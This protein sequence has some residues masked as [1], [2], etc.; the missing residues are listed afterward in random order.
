MS[1]FFATISVSE[2]GWSVIVVGVVVAIIRGDLVP[3]STHESVKEDRDFWRE[4]ARRAI[5]VND[6]AVAVAEKVAD[7]DSGTKSPRTGEE[8][9]P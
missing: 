3:R 4:A 5:E 1:D 6:T 2:I 8:D 9:Q 7:Q